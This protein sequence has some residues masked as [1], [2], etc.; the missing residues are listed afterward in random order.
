MIS[1]I[2]LSND[3]QE[4][5][6]LLLDGQSFNVSASKL[7]ANAMDAWTRRERIFHGTVAV[8][9]NIKIQAITPLGGNAVNISFSDG[10]DRAIYPYR[11]L[12]SLAKAADN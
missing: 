1:Q 2:T 4:L 10:H 6:F 3:S 9:P 12:E 8:E 7:R 5:R 11:Y